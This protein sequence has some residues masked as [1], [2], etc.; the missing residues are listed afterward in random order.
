MSLLV[1]QFR[2]MVSKDKDA[3]MRDEAQADVGYPT[4][5]LNFDFINGCVVH[6]KNEEKKL[7]YK[8]FSIGLTDGSFIMIIG[9]SGCGKTTFLAEIAANIVRPFSTSCIFEDSIEGGL[10]WSRREVLSGFHERELQER[11]IVRNAGVTAENFYKRIKMIHDIKL[12]DP[13]KYKYDTGLLD[14]FGNKIY[15]FEP[16]IYALDSIAMIMPDKNTEEDELSGGMS[17]TAGA[18]VIAQIFRTIIPMLKTANIM[19]FVV[20]HI[21]QDVQINPMMHSKSQVAY[22]NQG[23]RLPKGNT[24][25]YLANNIIR[26]DDANKL[27]ENETFNISGS[28]VEAKLVKS[29]SNRANQSTKLVFNQDIGYDPTLSLFLFLKE[30]GRIN[31]AGVGMYVDGYTDCKFAQKNLKDKLASNPEFKA[32]FMKACSEE[33]TK[34]PRYIEDKNVEEN[35]MIDGIL[36]LT[37]NNSMEVNE[38]DTK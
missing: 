9:R 8:Y 38:V 3:R 35:D 6:V 7:D 13:D 27:K 15:K 25:I 23:E 17:T 19:L 26:L 24:I 10:L 20:N 34:I 14:T 16:T 31:G 12:A 22:L 4:G 36:S 30:K 29:R 11:Y 18:K 33:L 5:F 21:M 28:I 37:K 2:A 32:V 1:D